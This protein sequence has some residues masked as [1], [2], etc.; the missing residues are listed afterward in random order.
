MRAG[1]LSRVGAKPHHAGKGPSAT[2]KKHLSRTQVT[3]K[4]QN[5][6][7]LTRNG[8]D[9]AAFWTGTHEIQA[10]KG[11]RRRR[12]TR[13]P[14]RSG[15]RCRAEALHDSVTFDVKNLKWDDSMPTAARPTSVESGRGARKS[16]PAERCRINPAIRSCRQIHINCGRWESRLVDLREASRSQ[17]GFS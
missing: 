6:F 3:S 12:R 13:K 7:I 1:G 4:K 17:P 2:R 15:S 9:R 11:F 8:A 5:R 10:G 16:P 14:R